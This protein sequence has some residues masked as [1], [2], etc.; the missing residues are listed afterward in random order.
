MR[1][2]GID[3]AVFL[4]TLSEHPVSVHVISI[5]MRVR[6]EFSVTLVHDRLFSGEVF[7]RRDG[8]FV[9]NPPG[10]EAKQESLK[11]ALDCIHGEIL[12]RQED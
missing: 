7:E 3:P 8:S 12:R 6:G 9:A 11:M 1:V 2:R 4:K 5:D 10:P